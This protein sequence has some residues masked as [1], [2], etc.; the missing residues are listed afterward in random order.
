MAG[1]VYRPAMNGGLYSIAI[2]NPSDPTPYNIAKD[3]DVTVV[4]YNKSKVIANYTFRKGELK[5]GDVGKIVSE[6]SNIV[7]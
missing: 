6:V 7:R 5:A 1:S 4:L 2:D 3:A